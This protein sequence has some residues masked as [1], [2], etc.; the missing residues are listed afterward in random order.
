MRVFERYVV[1]AIAALALIIAVAVQSGFLNVSAVTSAFIGGA[2]GLAVPDLDDPAMIRR[3]AGHYDRVCAACHGSP[4][5]P[6]QGDDL[7][8]TPPAPKLH[9]RIED[10]VPEALFLTVKHGIPNTAMPA[11]PTEDRDD[12][13]WAM[14]AFLTVL[15][16]LDAEAY[17]DLAYV[18][19]GDQDGEAL[20][21]GC[22]RC[23]GVD[24]RGHPNG[25]FPRLDIQ[26]ESYLLAALMAFRDGAR[27]SGI[28][29]SA[30][31]GL[32]DEELAALAAH[33]AAGPAVTES[34]SDAPALVASGAP[35]R[36]IAACGACHGPPVPARPDFPSLGGQYETY[37]L[38][39]LQLFASG[40]RGG[41]PFVDLMHSAARGLTDTERAALASWYSGQG[42]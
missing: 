29:Q 33:F 37:L 34:G 10:R 20:V 39:Q 6:E 1:A 36:Q 12:E 19:A 38:T 5:R 35:L 2:T 30:V 23:H 24:G 18:D 41:G 8:L 40:R 4:A 25:A 13:V 17:G 3:A 11:W 31:T 7:A 26:S 22:I 27:D 21:T 16:D 32:L 28:M 9:L 42:E 14:V 15:P